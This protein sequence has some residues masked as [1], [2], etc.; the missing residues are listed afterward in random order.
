MLLRNGSYASLCPLN[1]SGE[2]QSATW[3]FPS[4]RPF[5]S[6]GHR[7]QSSHKSAL[8]PLPHSCKHSVKKHVCQQSA[9]MCQQNLTKTFQPMWTVPKTFP[10]A[11]GT[12]SQAQINRLYCPRKFRLTNLSTALCQRTLTKTF[13]KHG[14]FRPKPSVKKGRG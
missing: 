10:S 6:K 11:N 3:T 2:G 14:L 9:R 7:Q 1:I 5:V 12:I 4:L 8:L 13:L